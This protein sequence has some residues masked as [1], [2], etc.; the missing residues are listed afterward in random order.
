[1]EKIRQKR[2]LPNRQGYKFIAIYENGNRIEQSIMKDSKGLHYIENYKE[3][4]G[5]ISYPYHC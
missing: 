1:M 4:I 3:I 2:D 5:W